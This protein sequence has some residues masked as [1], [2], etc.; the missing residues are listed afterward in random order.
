M[1][2]S[3]ER[4]VWIAATLPLAPLALI[5]YASLEWLFF[6]TKPSTLSTLPLTTQLT[7]LAR[8]PLPMLWALLAL[9]FV[10]SLLSVIAFPRLRALAMVPAA[11]VGGALLLIL[12]DNFTYTIL[13]FGA[14]TSDGFVRA[15]YAGLLPVLAVVA[16]RTL[17][18]W[19]S[20]WAQS[21]ACAAAGAMVAVLLALAPAVPDA[22]EAQA[23]VA[24]PPEMRAGGNGSLP[25]VLVIGIDGVDASRLSAYGYARPTTPFLEELRDE[26]LFFE[27]AFA[28]VGR[29]H[30][31][32]VSLLTGR[33]PF[34]SH[35]TFPP[36]ALQGDDVHRHLPGLLKPLGYT[37]L[38]LGM[39]HYAD[40]EDANLLGFDAAN[41]RWQEVGDVKRA[42]GN[43][44]EA[45]VFRRELAE[46]IDERIGHLFGWRHAID[47]Y[48]HV[49]G[50]TE[51]P[52]WEDDRRVATLTRYLPTAPEPFFV[53]AHF[54][55]T[56]CCVYSPKSIVFSGDDR[57]RDALDSQLRET[58]QQ[59]RR[60]I[61]ALRA[62]G[63]LERTI[64]VI[65]SDHTNGWTTK[66]RVPLLIRFPNRAL[67]GRVRANVQ[68]VDIAPT[69]ADYLGLG[70]PG[71]M[72][73][74][75]LLDES[76]R[77]RPRP[78]FGI[79]E[80]AERHG[81]GFRLTALDDA[82]PPNY[83]AGTATLVVGSRWFE[84]SLADGSIESG[85]VAGHTVPDAE[86]LADD[87][88]ALMLRRELDR[89]GFVVHGPA[90]RP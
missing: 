41:Y 60:V 61:D 12:L 65:T 49:E 74:V 57:T 24:A 81:V 53:H 22:V 55:D 19:S 66:G 89:Y 29:T 8:T 7:V 11:A 43:D 73:G 84:L 50:R 25:N 35:V 63:R 47:V 9:Q 56:H 76:T 39:R 40:A 1:S 6:V 75:S 15:L 14:L 78:I 31:S 27:N 52:Y 10:S 2:A 72:D 4:L 86:P 85:P 88:A 59:L 71:W 62:S 80:V 20:V 87:A 16:G 51:S 70:V 34:S 28:N 23:D 17:L 36:T 42:S 48:A 58:D 18:E 46:R 45:A 32:L 83:G 64:V 3:R 67:A 44:D 26:S 82:G 21:R 79:S 38:Q 68:L 37:S 33:L 69:I 90:E 54:L 30:G 77:D 13:G 5:V